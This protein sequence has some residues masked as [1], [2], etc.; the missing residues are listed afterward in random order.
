[1]TTED[2]LAS[3]SGFSTTELALFSSLFS[4]SF[5]IFILRFYYYYYI[6]I[7]IRTQWYY[8]FSGFTKAAVYI[9][10][11]RQGNNFSINFKQEQELP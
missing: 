11:L 6:I 8:L 5:F 3:L 4:P 10:T 7:K 1:M 9:E 2:Y